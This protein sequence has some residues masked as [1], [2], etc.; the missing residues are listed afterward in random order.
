MI[1]PK[2]GLYFK[3]SEP[4]RIYK[5]SHIDNNNWYGHYVGPEYHAVKR[6]VSGPVDSFKYDNENY[7]QLL[8]D[9]ERILYVSSE[10]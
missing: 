8:T 6:G 5:I 10:S 7:Y 1:I 2:P 9:A 4:L 3:V